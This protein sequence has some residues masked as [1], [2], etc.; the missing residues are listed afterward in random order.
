[1]F[2]YALIFIIVGYLIQTALPWYSLALLALVLAYSAKFKPLQSL[3]LFFLLG[4]LLWI[5][6]AYWKDTQSRAHLSDRIGILFGVKN[7]FILLGV[8]SVIGGITSGLG[9]WCGSLF[10]K[11]LRE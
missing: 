10:A 4:A 5:T 1:M 6:V 8:T 9:A 3:I 2:V 7:L 11:Y